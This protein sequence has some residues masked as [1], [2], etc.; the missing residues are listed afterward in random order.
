MRLQEKNGQFMLTLPRAVID[1]IGWKK[2][3][4]IQIKIAG[5]D[6]LELVKG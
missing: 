3:D 1:G 6:R 4:E 5:K 2:F